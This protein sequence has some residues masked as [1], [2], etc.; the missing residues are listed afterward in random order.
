MLFWKIKCLSIDYTVNTI[1][2]I[3]LGLTIN[4]IFEAK[5]AP[6]SLAAL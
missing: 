5:T 2:L 6:K 4:I 1:G 3:I